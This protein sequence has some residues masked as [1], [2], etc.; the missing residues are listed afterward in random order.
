MKCLRRDS[1]SFK[2]VLFFEKGRGATRTT[3]FVVRCLLLPEGYDDV[4]FCYPYDSLTSHFVY[5]RHVT[6]DR[7]Q[8]ETVRDD[9][10]RLRFVICAR[11]TVVTRARHEPQS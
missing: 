8:H 7:V 9:V 6:A 1:D 11:T 3:S 10:V 2:I 5:N 4:V